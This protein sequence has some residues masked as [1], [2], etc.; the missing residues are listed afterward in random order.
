MG[1]IGVPCVRVIQ[2]GT[3]GDYR[4][5]VIRTKGGASGQVKVPVVIWNEADR[6]WLEEHVMYDI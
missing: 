6:T 3:F 2:P 4:E 5:W 1:K